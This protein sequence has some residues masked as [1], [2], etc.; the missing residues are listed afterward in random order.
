MAYD[1]NEISIEKMICQYLYGKMSAPS[2]FLDNSI[3]RPSDPEFVSIVKVNMY[4]FME[5]GPGRF[6][7]GAESKLVETFF[8][9]AT[10]L[11]W[12]EPG[13][14]YTKAEVLLQLGLT[15]NDDRIIV[16]QSELSDGRDDY[17]QRS[18]IWNSGLFKVADDVIFHMGADGALSIQNYS[19][20][21]Y[22][23]NFDFNGG[24]LL[25]EI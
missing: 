7:F 19:V 9:S 13:G 18:F 17:M 6:A 12:M 10:D 5:S 21:P 11:S 24:G 25:A 2:D 16:R 3:I 1:W 15:A 20:R 4:S 8:N 22:D 23:D 14:S